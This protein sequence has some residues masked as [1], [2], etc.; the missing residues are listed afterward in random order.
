MWKFLLLVCPSSHAVG[1]AEYCLRCDG[2]AGPCMG[3]AWCC[4]RSLNR[5]VLCFGCLRGGNRFTWGYSVFFMQWEVSGFLG[6]QGVLLRESGGT[7]SDRQKAR[8]RGVSPEL[9]GLPDRG[10]PSEL[11]I[12]WSWGCSPELKLL[13]QIQAPTRSLDL[14]RQF[15]HH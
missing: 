3:A 9:G 14:L 6:S 5:F 4:G 8:Y 7:T 12:P 10:G 13:Q 11:A 1:Q 2:L 15:E